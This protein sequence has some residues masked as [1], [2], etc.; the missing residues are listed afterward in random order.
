[1]KRIHIVPLVLFSWGCANRT[2]Q[3][4]LKVDLDKN[5]W[6]TTVLADGHV[7]N[8]FNRLGETHTFTDDTPHKVW[9]SAQEVSSTVPPGEYFLSDELRERSTITVEFEGKPF[10]YTLGSDRKN[11]EAPTKLSNLWAMMYGMYKW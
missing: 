2:D 8:G 9:A 1:V 11:P 3:V 10:R 6:L 7:Q 5:A 4:S